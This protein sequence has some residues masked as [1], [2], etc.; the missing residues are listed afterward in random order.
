MKVTYIYHSGYCIELNDAIYI[1][2]YYK[3]ELPRFPDD[4]LIYVFASHKHH[5]HFTLEIFR[6]LEA[7]PNVIYI[8]SNDI[9]LNDNYLERNGISKDWKEKIISLKANAAVQIGGITIETLKSTDAGVAFLVSNGKR[10]VYHAGDL[11]WWH[12]E[13]E[14]EAFNRS[15]ARDYKQSI[16]KIAGREID[17]A[18]LPLDSR[19]KEGYWWGIHYFMEHTKTKVVFPMHMWDQYSL[20]QELKKREETKEYKR[21]IVDVEQEGQSWEL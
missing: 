10:T 21:R 2:D 19:Q 1:F 15:M 4:K 3:G 7:Y 17:I 16:D 20:I 11:H 6:K 14:S 9:K 12:W 13:G 18:F 5:D 8:F